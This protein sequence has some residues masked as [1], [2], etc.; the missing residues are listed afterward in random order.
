MC[1]VHC[2]LKSTAVRITIS[3]EISFLNVSSHALKSLPSPV[4]I[5]HPIAYYT[6]LCNAIWINEPSVVETRGRCDNIQ[7]LSWITKWNLNDTQQGFNCRC[8]RPALQSLNQQTNRATAACHADKL[9]IIISSTWLHQKWRGSSIELSNNAFKFKNGIYANRS[10]N[11]IE[12][13]GAARENFELNP[14]GDL[15]F[16][17][18]LWILN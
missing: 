7:S 11:P 18:P 1:N 13:D 14:V 5:K 17:S 12:I 8:N 3:H 15:F 4:P 9:S 2:R 6:C 16:H 10:Q